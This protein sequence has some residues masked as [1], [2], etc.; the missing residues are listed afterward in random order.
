MPAMSAK[1]IL[2]LLLALLLPTV[3]LRAQSVQ[4]DSLGIFIKARID[5]IIAANPVLMDRS[6]LGLYVYDLTADTALYC[7]GIHQCM[8]PASTQ[9]VITAV[10]ALHHL[11]G[12]HR[13]RTTLGITGSAIDT[14]EVRTWHGDIVV[15]GSM[16]PRLG[17]EE[18]SHFV[19]AIRRLNV[20]R[21]DGNIV[22]DLTFKD[23]I[24]MGWGWCWDDTPIP[25]T[26]LTYKGKDCFGR[27]FLDAIHQAGIS[28]GGC[29]HQAYTKSELPSDSLHILCERSASIDQILERMMKRSNNQYAESL[30]YQLGPT[31]KAAA[32]RVYNLLEM[33]DL[34]IKTLQVADGSGL[35]LYN[36]TTPEALVLTLRYA[37][38]HPEIY[39]HLQPALP[40]AGHDGTL[41]RRM[42]SGAAL[43]RVMAKTGTVEGVSTLAGYAQAPGGHM[44]AFAIM[45]QGIRHTASGHRFQDAVCQA[46]CTPFSHTI[47]DD[48]PTQDPQPLPSEPDEDQTIP[49]PLP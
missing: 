28:L 2:T 19:N 49:Q 44:L 23:S 41:R 7:H 29:V 1:H 27:Q 48:T 36:Y 46:L 24:P 21:I 33:L 34:D 38:H 4:E 45:N 42:T 12:N 31:T 17:S 32:R 30:F 18:L 6:Q 25:L 15:R 16:D 40:L 5:S 14:G 20:A 8:R 13:L 9:K 47:M 3:P 22:L 35:S 26:P 11:G 43:R 10:A 39:R 37:Y